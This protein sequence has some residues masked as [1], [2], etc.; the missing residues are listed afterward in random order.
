MVEKDKDEKIHSQN[1]TKVHK[2]IPK[3]LLNRK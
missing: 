1:V 3:M 2:N